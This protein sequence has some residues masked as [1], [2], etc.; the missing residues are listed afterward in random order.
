MCLD[1][2]NNLG[3]TCVLHNVPLF[4]RCSNG[5]DGTLTQ[6]EVPSSTG[7][8]DA[9]ARGLVQPDMAAAP[10]DK[11]DRSITLK[12]EEELQTLVDCLCQSSMPKYVPSLKTDVLACIAL[13]AQVQA[14]TVH[15]VAVFCPRATGAL[16]SLA[17]MGALFQQGTGRVSEGRL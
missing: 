6:P 14:S 9:I 11:D 1:E 17:R 15:L 16:C 2:Q 10:S 5:R 4:A 7:L 12:A 8:A 13:F 3:S